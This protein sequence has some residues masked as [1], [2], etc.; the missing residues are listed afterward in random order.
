MAKADLKMMT[1][2]GV[3]TF[4]RVKL[5]LHTPTNTPYALKCMRK[6]QIIALKQ[7]GRVGVRVRVRVRARV[8]RSSRSSRWRPYPTPTPTPSPTP[9]PNRWST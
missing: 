9:I 7:V 8:S 4:G 1:I 6:G 2:L 5:V 3:G